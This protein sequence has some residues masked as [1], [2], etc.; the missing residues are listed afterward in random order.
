[1]NIDTEGDRVLFIRTVVQHLVS[2]LQCN[3]SPS[4]NLLPSQAVKANLRLNTKKLYEADG[5]AVQ[6]LLKG[7]MVLY[8]A[9]KSVKSTED[10]D[11][12]QDELFNEQ[13]IRAKLSEFK[14]C[15]ELAS[16]I[17]SR[18]ANLYDELAKEIELRVRILSYA[19]TCVLMS[20]FISGT[21]NVCLD[22]I[23]QSSRS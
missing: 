16:E 17:T 15:R 12:E 4:I 5:H 22:S 13:A 7:V 18:G 2:V 20:F 8:D 1:M 21:T 14:R 3:S 10:E 6:E 19:G 11:D 23:S 9:S